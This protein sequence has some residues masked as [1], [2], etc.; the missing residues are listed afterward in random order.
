M[1]SKGGV[2]IYILLTVLTVGGGVWLQNL[3]TTLHDL[4]K[5]NVKLSERMTRLE[6]VIGLD[7]P[8]HLKPETLDN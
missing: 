1:N 2:I 5:E 3:T 4:H 8:P 7:L 6:V